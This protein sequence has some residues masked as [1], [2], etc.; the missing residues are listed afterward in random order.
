MNWCLFSGGG[1]I[2]YCGCRY[3]NWK[4][5]PCLTRVEDPPWLTREQ[6]KW[7]Q[8]SWTVPIDDAAPFRASPPSKTPSHSLALSWTSL[9]IPTSPLTALKNSPDNRFYY[10][11]FL[12][13]SAYWIR[14]CH[15]LTG[16]TSSSHCRLSHMFMLF[17]HKFI[18]CNIIIKNCWLVIRVWMWWRTNISSLLK[19]SGCWN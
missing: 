7:R 19:M 11:W 14:N 18:Y 16:A 8:A 4:R 5:I 2:W 9:H 15:S 12:F 6:W 13:S 10:S 3:G 17:R 1:V